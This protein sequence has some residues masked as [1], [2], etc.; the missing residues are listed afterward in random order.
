MKLTERRD[1]L[2]FADTAN[3]SDIE[4]ALKR[5]FVSGI[6]T[7]PSLL[8][9]EPRAN[10]ETHIGRI[11]EL[12][13]KYSPGIH[14]SVEVFSRDPEVILKQ[15]KRFMKVFDY[16]ELGVK[17]H[18]GWDELAVIKALADEGIAV[19]CTAN[20]KITQAV[21]AA[22]VGAR[23]VSIFVNRIQDSGVRI[24]NERILSCIEFIKETES[25]TAKNEL[26]RKLDWLVNHLKNS[27]E[28]IRDGS[29]EEEDFDPLNV[30]GGFREILDRTGLPTQI[31]AGSIRCAADVKKAFL[32]GA[33][34]V[35]VPPKFFSQMIR[36]HKTDEVIDRFIAD[37]GKWTAG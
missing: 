2:I 15:A 28:A 29:L 30:I 31:I 35:T 6:T 12:I 18:I 3:L 24:L 4:E 25:E 7:N 34:I 8:A 36:H 32:S 13:S 5:G 23:F 22:S 33:H 10:F 37:F 16:R 27:V 11:V 26:G 19:N 21:M 17:V 9:K 14:L 20:M 1:M